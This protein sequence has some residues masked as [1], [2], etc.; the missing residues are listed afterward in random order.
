M[1]SK[2]ILSLLAV[3]ALATTVLV[4]CGSKDEAASTNEVAFKDG[5][6]TEKST[7][8]ERGYVAEISIEVKDGKI[9]TVKYDETSA[10]GVTK[11]TDEAYNKMMLDNG[12]KSSP[13][14]AFPKLQDALVEKQD[15]EAVDAVAS[16][17]TSSDSF[18][19]LAAKAL[20][21]A[22]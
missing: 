20:E 13:A 22:K 16:V 2:K 15:V 19:T 10:D 6:Y 5:V 9:A 17:T 7:A 4:G 8:D 12:M 1:K 3:A 11:S 14:E 21:K 18:K